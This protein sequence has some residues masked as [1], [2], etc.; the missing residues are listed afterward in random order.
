LSVTYHPQRQKQHTIHSPT[1]HRRLQLVLHIASAILRKANSHT[2]RRRRALINTVLERRLLARAT[3]HI[4]AVEVEV[5]ARVE[6]LVVGLVY[7]TVVAGAGDAG[8]AY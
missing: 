6:V 2:A 3:D 1:V 4:T 7:A 5:A 8:C